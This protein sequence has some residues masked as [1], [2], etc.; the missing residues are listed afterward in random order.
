[1]VPLTRVDSYHSSAVK[2]ASPTNRLRSIWRPPLLE[3][4]RQAARPVAGVLARHPALSRRDH[5]Y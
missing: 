5:E 4:R 2:V 1:L 3:P